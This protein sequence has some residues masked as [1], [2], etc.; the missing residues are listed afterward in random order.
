MDDGN[1]NTMAMANDGIVII[2][3]VMLTLTI[4]NDAF[5]IAVSIGLGFSWIG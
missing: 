5:F 2:I 1:P 3:S 4:A